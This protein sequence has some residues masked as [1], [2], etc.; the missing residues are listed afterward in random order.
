MTQ[1]LRQLLIVED[2]AATRDTLRLELEA[3]VRIEAV[4]T[5][6]SLTEA[7]AW[8][9]HH[10][11][12][13]LL[14]DVDLPDGSGLLLIPETRAQTTPARCLVLS[15]LN[16]E[17]TI[18]RGIRLGAEG[19]LLKQDAGAGV[20]DALFE[21]LAGRPALSPAVAQC[22]MAQL[23]ETQSETSLSPTGPSL[24]PRQQQTLALLA[25]GLTYQEIAE[26]ME[27]SFHTV[28]AYAQEIY[29]KLAARSRSEAVFLARE[30]GL[31]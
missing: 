13:V 20:A 24:P 30:M 7:R 12:D 27:I 6:G 17:A 8:L 2:D 10:A 9:T 11:A 31:L 23:R 21:I 16:D 19:Y 5:A 22:I 26:Q 18:V 28:S 4:A 29:G 1:R 15:A 14:L 25:R 3:D